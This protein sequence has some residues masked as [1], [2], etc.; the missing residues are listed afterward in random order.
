MF[1]EYS[2]GSA[3]WLCAP[4]RQAPGVGA[5]E[6]ETETWGLHPAS[7]RP[8]ADP[9]PLPPGPL[10]A[11]GPSCPTSQNPI[12]QYPLDRWGF[13]SSE[14]QISTFSKK[15]S[16]IFKLNITLAALALTSFGICGINV[17]SAS[18]WSCLEPAASSAHFT[19]VNAESVGKG[20]GPPRLADRASRGPVCPHQP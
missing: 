9:P 14:S 16:R 17:H 3:G 6:G 12:S 5:G 11:S 4:Q 18:F 20:K 15:L 10:S 8:G 13:S 7:P 1:L 19:D 2:A